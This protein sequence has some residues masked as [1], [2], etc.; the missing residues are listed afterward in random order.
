MPKRLM[1]IGMLG[2]VVLTAGSYLYWMYKP[3]SARLLPFHSWMNNPA[4]HPD[5]KLAAGSQYGSDRLFF[6]SMSSLAS[7]GVTA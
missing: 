4:S 7:S 5:W 3:N 2:A 6:P 1:L